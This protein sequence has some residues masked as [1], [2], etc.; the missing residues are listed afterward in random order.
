[1]G[2]FLHGYRWTGL[3]EY[4]VLFLHYEYPGKHSGT[5]CNGLLVYQWFTLKIRQLRESCSSIPLHPTFSANKHRHRCLKM[6]FSP[7]LELFKHLRESF[8]SPR[9]RNTLYSY[10]VSSENPPCP[11][12]FKIKL[13]WSQAAEVASGAVHPLPS[14]SKSNTLW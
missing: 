2:R 10:R 4:Y 7:I 5:T 3:G 13:S 11:I 1:M 14:R 6:L 9:P 8:E 12:R